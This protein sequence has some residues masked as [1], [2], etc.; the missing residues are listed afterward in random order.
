VTSLTALMAMYFDA[1]STA[2]TAAERKTVKN[3]MLLGHSSFFIAVSVE[4]LGPI[5]Q[6]ARQF[7]VD[8]CSGSLSRL[9]TVPFCFH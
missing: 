5:H 9:V 7:L 6:S 8:R 1:G 3:A 4:S 2:E